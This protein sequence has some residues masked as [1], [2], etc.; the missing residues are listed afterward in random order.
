MKVFSRGAFRIGHNPDFGEPVLSHVTQI[1]M[2]MTMTLKEIVLSNNAFH[3]VYI[4]LK[5]MIV[6]SYINCFN[7]SVLSIYLLHY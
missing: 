2:I 6:K 1:I 4:F 3:S 7:E 5:L